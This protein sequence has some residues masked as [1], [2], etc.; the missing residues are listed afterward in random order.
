MI[1]GIILL[2]LGGITAGSFYIPLKKVER[3]SW[4]SGWI[5]NGLFSWLIGPVIVAAC[6]VPG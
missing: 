2:V 1:F 3:W 6:T 5:I 4:E